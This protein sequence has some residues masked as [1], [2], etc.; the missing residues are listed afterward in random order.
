MFG[1][2]GLALNWVISAIVVVAIVAV[3]AKLL[4]ARR[5]NK[6]YKSRSCI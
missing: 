4:T 3:F 2:I 1:T 5:L 6:Y